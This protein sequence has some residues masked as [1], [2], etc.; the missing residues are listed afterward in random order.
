MKIHILDGP[1]SG[2]TTLAQE[3]SEKFHIPHFDL[4]QIGWRRGDQ[5]VAYI[6]EATTIAEQPDWITEG[7]FLMWTD[8]LLYHA[9][10]IILLDVSWPVAAWR[11]IVRH[12]VKSLRGTNHYPGIKLLFNFLKSTRRYYKDKVSA[13]TPEAKLMRLYFEE[14]DETVALPD[15][16]ALLMCLEKY[17]AAFPFG[18]EF[19]RLYLAKYKEKVFVVKNNDERKRLLKYLTSRA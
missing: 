6:E 5:S 19:T 12:I 2:K 7:I 9:D 17:K 11:I 1:G 4:E 15:A 18:A 10:Y 3:L 13:D 8:P 14:H 16:E